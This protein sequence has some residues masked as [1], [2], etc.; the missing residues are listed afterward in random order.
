MFVREREEKKNGCLYSGC[1]PA[2]LLPKNTL[3]DL[4]TFSPSSRPEAA[5]QSRQ[6]AAISLLLSGDQT[7]PVGDLN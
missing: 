2:K 3:S 1:R 4:Q 6:P 7:Q 5:V